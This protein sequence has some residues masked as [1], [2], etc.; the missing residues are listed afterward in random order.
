MTNLTSLEIPN[1]VTKIGARAFAGNN[2]HE[3]VIPSSVTEIGQYA[4]STKNYLSEPCTLTLPEGLTTIGNRAFRNKVIAEVTL[5]TT[6]TAL[7]ANVFEKE[8]SDGTQPVIT[9]VLVNDYNQYENKTKFPVSD[10]HTVLYTGA[11]HWTAE[12]FAYGTYTLT[13]N[14][15]VQMGN[16]TSDQ[17]TGDIYVVTGLTDLGKQK[18]L[19]NQ[20]LVI[21]AEDPS[22]NRIQGIGTDAFNA[23]NKNSVLYDLDVT[24]SSVELPVTAKVENTHWDTSVAERGDFFILSGAFANNALSYVNIPEGTLYIGRNAFQ[25]NALEVVELPSSLMVI[26]QTAFVSNTT[27]TSNRIREIEFPASTDFPLSIGVQAFGFNRLRDLQLPS[28]TAAVHKYAFIANTGMEEVDPSGTAAEKKG[29][30]IYMYIDNANPSADIAHTE[31][32]G[33][34]VYGKSNVQ[35][36]I[37]GTMPERWNY[38]DFTYDETGTVIKGLSE[39]GQAKVLVNPYLVTPYDMVTEIAQA[40]FANNKNIKTVVITDNITKIGNGAF[41]ANSNLEEVTLSK[42]LTEIPQAAFNSTNLKTVVIPEGVISIGNNAFTGNME[43]T[44]LT[45]PSTLKTIGNSAF[46]NHQLTRLI[47]PASVTSIGNYAFRV[48]NENLQNTLTELTLNEGLESIGNAAFGR[49]ALTDVTLPSTV[50]T[51]HKNAFLNSTDTV[52]VYT[53]NAAL[54]AS[55]NPAGQMNIILSSRAVTFDACGGTVDP[56]IMFTGDKGKLDELPV[57]VSDN[58]DLTFGGWLDGETIVTEDTV[59][60]FDTVLK[61]K[62]EGDG[63]IILVQPTDTYSPAGETVSYS[64]E[65]INAESYQWYY[66]KNGTKWYKSA[67]D[68]NDSATV[69]LIVKSNNINNQYRCTLTGTDGETLDTLVVRNEINDTPLVIN[70]IAVSDPAATETITVTAENAASY[71]LYYSKD[72]SKWYKSSLEGTV[73]ADGSSCSYELTLSTGNMNNLYK[74]KVT[75]TDGTKTDTDAVSLTGVPVITNNPEDI[76]VAIGNNAEFSVE[77]DN[78]AIWQWYYSKDG[79]EKWYK[80]LAAGADTPSMSLTAK[81]S[82]NNMLYRCKITGASG[83]SVVSE[84]AVLT[85]G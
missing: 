27:K 73:A 70:G 8:Y 16:D 65:A 56:E 54:L 71:E 26:Y 82:N 15:G 81:K 63:L 46:G 31:N 39:N 55:D 1:T 74:C 72:G 53:G 23:T 79:G 3:I 24:L 84:A 22:G 47:I 48:N 78:A 21:P 17:L 7:S 43:L 32:T 52:D 33:T 20:E 41:T 51:L 68:G 67:A 64:V 13:R 14:D 25:N 61:A 83:L 4:F 58:P 44:S 9:R 2:I 10:Y 30:V 37:T 49:S 11:D 77:A 60:A 42:N 12:D 38:E 36:L 28:N 59:Y 75:G 18:V 29:G 80:S 62:W 19:I 6:V 5:P 76:T 57:P 35:K 66:S 69:S 45:L 85:V 50:T 34:G 40:A